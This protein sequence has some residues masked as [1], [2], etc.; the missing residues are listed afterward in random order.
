M[1]RDGHKA[2]ISL[3]REG[4]RGKIGHES[5]ERLSE[6]PPPPVFKDMDAF[7]QRSVVSSRRAAETE[8]VPGQ[9]TLAAQCVVGHDRPAADRAA[10]PRA[11]RLPYARETIPAFSAEAMRV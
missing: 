6:L 10:A 7:P 1:K 9:A 2:V 4:L 8:A 11:I 5:G 3:P